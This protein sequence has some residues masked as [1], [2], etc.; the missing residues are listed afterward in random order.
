MDFYRNTF[1]DLQE[2]SGVPWGFFFWILFMDFSYISIHFFKKFSN[3]S[4]KSFRGFSTNYFREFSRNRLRYSFGIFRELKKEYLQG[5]IQQVFWSLFRCSF[6]SYFR[7]SF[8]SSVRGFSWNSSRKSSRK[9]IRSSI[10]DLFRKFFRDSS[11]IF[12][13]I[14]PEMHSGYLFRNSFKY[15]SRSSIRDSSWS[16]FKIPPGFILKFGLVFSKFSGIPLEI[17]AGIHPRLLLQISS[18]IS[19]PDSSSDFFK[20]SIKNFI[21]DSSTNFF[22]NSSRIFP[23]FLLE[24][25]SEVLWGISLWSSLRDFWDWEKLLLGFLL[26]NLLFFFLYKRVF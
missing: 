23:G 8:K 25:S 15:S 14:H 16:S 3:F 12:G 11:R 20:N 5:F 2:L 18:G 22:G 10:G 17:S 6:T 26:K 1:K 21:K 24:I 7:D 4:R 9:L 19:S 13:A